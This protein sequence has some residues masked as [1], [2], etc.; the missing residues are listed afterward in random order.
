MRENEAHREVI[1][2]VEA[3]R[4][5]L[6]DVLETLPTM[7]CLLTPDYH[8][9]FANRSYREKFGES[10]GRYCYEYCLGRTKPLRSANPLKY[11]KQGSPT[12][13]KSTTR[14]GT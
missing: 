13:G 5:R 10:D 7:I 4:R 6:F 11:L 9:A 3:E 14:M 8:V 12:I 2:A 1:E